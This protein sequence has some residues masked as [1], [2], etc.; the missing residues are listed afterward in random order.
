MDVVPV[1]AGSRSSVFASDQLKWKGEAA[2]SE[3]E[4]M[5]RQVSALCTYCEVQRLVR[6]SSLPHQ[7]HRAA[8]YLGQ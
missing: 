6:G 5:S 8:Q 4:S 7:R 1:I 2:I 3:L